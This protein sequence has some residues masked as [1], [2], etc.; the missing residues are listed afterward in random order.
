[1]DRVAAIASRAL[2]GL[3]LALWGLPA[4]PAGA[5]EILVKLRHQGPHAI[6]DCAQARHQRGEALAPVARDRSDSLDRLHAELG[7]RGVRAL[8]RRPDGRPFETQRRAL[9]ARAAARRQALPPAARGALPE[10]V[11]LAHVYRLALPEGADARRAAARYAADPHVAWAQ[12]NFGVDLDILS[13]EPLQLSSDFVADDPLLFSSGSW[14]QAYAD[15]WGVHRVRAP[16]AWATARGEGIVIAVVDT[17]VD[18]AH[19]DLADNMWVNPGE[20]LDGDGRAT[21]ADHNG[22]DDDGNGFVDDL[23]GF[24]FANSLD[25]NDDGDYLDPGDVSDADPFD[26]NGHGTH[27]AG[28]AAAVGGNGIGVAGV[29]PA[30]RI[31]ALKGFRAEGSSTIEVLSRGMVYAALHGA[32]VIN[33]S[34]SCGQR[35]PSNPLAEEVSD[36]VRSL[37]VVVVTSAGNKGDDVVFYSP[38]NRRSTIAVGATTPDDERVFFSNTG[39]LVDVVAPGGADPFTP[40]VLLPQRAILSTLSSGAG[41]QAS[42]DGLFVVDEFY[43]RWAGTSMSAPHVAGLAA[44]ILSH[45]P[46]LDVE[47]V[48]ALIRSSAADLAR[49]GPDADTGLGLA[50]AAAALAAPTPTL[51][52]R[53][54]RPKVGAV[55]VPRE[56]EVGLGVALEGELAGA[57]LAVGAGFDPEAFEAL[58]QWSRAGEFRA[59]WAVEAFADGPYVLRLR[60]W[61]AAGDE[62]V[63]FR[64]LSLERNRPQR[65]SSG[66]GEASRATVSRHWVAWEELRESEEDPDAEPRREIHARPWSGGEAAA[67]AGGRDGARAPELS[68]VRL[69]WLEGEEAATRIYSCQ[70]RGAAGRCRPRER[71]PEPGTRRSLALAGRDLV[72]EEVIGG[73]PRLAGCRLAGRFCASLPMPDGEGAQ[74]APILGGGR[75]SWVAGRGVPRA[76]RSCAP[77][78]S[79]RCEPVAVET[80]PPALVFGGE[81]DLL[82]QIFVAGAGG[83]L[84]VC[85]LGA[86]GACAPILVGTTDLHSAVSG[87]RVAWS[88]PGPG[89]DADVFFCEFDPRV[90]DCPR[91]RV[92]GSGADQRR[93]AISGDH[94]VWE[95]DREGVPAIFG[96]ALPRLAPLS[97]RTLRVGQ[98]LALPVRG[99]APGGAPRLSALRVDGAPLEA[100][101]MRFH[102]RGDGTGWLSWTPRPAD[103][104]VHT[105]RFEARGRGGLV[106][107]RS[108]VLEVVPARP[109]DRGPPGARLRPPPGSP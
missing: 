48:R 62:I 78:P 72:W 59:A 63:E 37:G 86:D 8:F 80:A 65:F 44:L 73:E 57:E 10:P 85:A 101:G 3:W 70:L 92:T 23:H 21:E 26:D 4:A 98:R 33:N 29:A 45:R 88:A 38:E 76:L 102:D 30:A 60:A 40:G 46:E 41:P 106:A 6:A 67:V 74:S 89:G 105:L 79:D 56:G 97:D 7:V 20:D 9:A 103:L 82:T 61:T 71:T 66:E 2:A 81:G 18:T 94:L 25:A 22:V 95:D 27:V 11:E 108:L 91:Q 5:A 55:V 104:G 17:G 14:G 39:L 54:L 109:A 53:F 12:P 16:E 42:G 43:N 1:M 87:H 28:S 84:L 51:R 34:W 36:F 13:D 35:C 99:E 15:L 68:G 58:A 52:A 69:A 31:M 90:G 19:P 93:P 49:P 100:R 96:L 64:P 32:R 50:D 83:Q 107:R 75:L 77:F 24:D 47:A